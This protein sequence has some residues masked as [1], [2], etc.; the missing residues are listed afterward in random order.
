MWSMLYV[1]KVTE[2]RKKEAERSPLSQNAYTIDTH[3]HSELLFKHVILTVPLTCV[4]SHEMRVWVTSLTGPMKFV[5]HT[6]IPCK[7]TQFGGAATMMSF[8]RSSECA[9]VSIVYAAHHW[10]VVT[11]SFFLY[12][13]ILWLFVHTYAT[14]SQ[15]EEIQSCKLPPI[16]TRAQLKLSL[17]T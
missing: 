13:L 8:K 9:C 16:S 17:R 1:V 3:T 2:K 10:K 5:T 11:F 7:H 14:S 4:C 6:R 12:F 15:V